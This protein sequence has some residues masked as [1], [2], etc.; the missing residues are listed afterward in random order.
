MTAAA[1]E[2]LKAVQDKVGGYELTYDELDYGSG[3]AML[4]L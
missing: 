1:L 3:S 4:L 2:V